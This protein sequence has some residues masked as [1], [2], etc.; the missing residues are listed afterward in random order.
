MSSVGL[1][2]RNVLFLE[3]IMDL[4]LAVMPHEASTPWGSRVET[5]IEGRV[6]GVANH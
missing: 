2:R 4:P 3:N 6:L 5:S 1:Y